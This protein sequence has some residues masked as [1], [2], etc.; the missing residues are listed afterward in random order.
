MTLS[1]MGMR[2]G[3]FGCSVL[4]TFASPMPRMPENASKRP[5]SARQGIERAAPAKDE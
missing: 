5:V 1:S 2:A 3:R 4:V